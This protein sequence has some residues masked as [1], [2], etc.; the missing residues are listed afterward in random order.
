MIIQTT[1]AKTNAALTAKNMRK[2]LLDA[3]DGE[4]GTSSLSAGTTT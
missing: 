2:G 1:M 4:S 3:D